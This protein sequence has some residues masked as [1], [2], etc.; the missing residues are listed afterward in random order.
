MEYSFFQKDSLA[1]TDSSTSLLTDS[2]VPVK[3]KKK[4]KEDVQT[5]AVSDTDVT[6]LFA[7]STSITASADTTPKKTTNGH[8]QFFIT[9]K[10]QPSTYYTRTRQEPTPD[11]YTAM[12]LIIAVFITIIKVYYARVFQHLIK[13]FYNATAANQVVRE[14]NML[15]QRA[16]VVLNVVSY[17]VM[18]LY[19]YRVSEFYMFK[20]EWMGKGFVK[21]I[22]F[23]VLISI[24]YSVKMFLVKALGVVFNVDRPV[25]SYIYNL[26]LVN[27]ILGML[28]LPLLILISYVSY[29]YVPYLVLAS[30]IIALSI[31]LYR[32][33]KTI[34][35]WIGV[36]GFSLYYLILYLCAFEILPIMILARVAS[37]L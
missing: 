28:L 3:I 8:Q 6:T 18:A 19:F 35:L 30:I 23:A 27:I 22:F 1:L 11:W 34:Q 9:H 17:I 4:V 29:Q 14:E 15:V 2:V 16:T 21:F 24:A 25:A 10:L 26:F 36:P 37:I 33:I 32:M 12:L 31:F 20:P 5:L 13:S 7:D